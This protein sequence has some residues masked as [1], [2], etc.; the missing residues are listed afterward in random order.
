MEKT[1]LAK[2]LSVVSVKLVIPI[3]EELENVGA[4][5]PFRVIT[6]PDATICGWFDVVAWMAL[7]WPPL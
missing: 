7:N 2:T 3:V 4:G 6:T 1:A 5:W